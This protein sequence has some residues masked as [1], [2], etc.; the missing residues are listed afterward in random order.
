MDDGLQD[1]MGTRTR[2]GFRLGG[3][4]LLLRRHG[5]GG[6]K[7]TGRT[8]PSGAE[9]LIGRSVQM[10]SGFPQPILLFFTNSTR[11]A[12]ENSGVSQKLLEISGCLCYNFC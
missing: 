6:S 5:A 10:G 3:T 7:G 8:D 1:R 2:G 12:E 11:K 4:L 9:R